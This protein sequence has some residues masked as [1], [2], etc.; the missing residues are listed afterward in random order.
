MHAYY[1]NPHMTT[2]GPVIPHLEP[3][4]HQSVLTPNPPFKY[5]NDSSLSSQPHLVR[6]PGL[7]VW[8]QV[9]AV[10]HGVTHAAVDTLRGWG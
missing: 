1:Y 6:G 3:H 2:L 7:P 10:G 4:T 8:G 5:S 9:A